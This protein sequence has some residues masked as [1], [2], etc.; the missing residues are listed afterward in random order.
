MKISSYD[1]FPGYS[2]LKKRPIFLQMWRSDRTSQPYENH[3]HRREKFKRKSFPRLFTLILKKKK[4]SKKNRKKNIFTGTLCKC[5]YFVIF[6]KDPKSIEKYSLP[7]CCYY[8][9]TVRQHECF[10]CISEFFSAFGLFWVQIGLF[11]LKNGL[12][13]P[14][15]T[16]KQLQMAYF[17]PEN[18]TLLTWNFKKKTTCICT[19]NWLNSGSRDHP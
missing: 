1:T 2:S 18:S 6:Y 14:F 7:W 12:K 3:F 15:L 4:I 17:W 8:L 9:Q 16:R 10:D 13:W 11:W 5:A 19:T